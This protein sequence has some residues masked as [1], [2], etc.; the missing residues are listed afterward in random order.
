M[1]FATLI[2]EPWQLGSNDCWAFFR[3]VQREHFGRD[4]PM[5]DVDATSAMVCAQAVRDHPERLRWSAVAEP[6]AGDA[7]LMGKGRHP[8]HVGLWIDQDGGGVLHCQQ[9]TGVVFSRPAQ[10]ALMGWVNTSYWRAK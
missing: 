6:R 2:G 10:L 4:V 7:V 8:T 3:R 5:V 9:G 1:N